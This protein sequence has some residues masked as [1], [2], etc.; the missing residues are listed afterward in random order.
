MTSDPRTAVGTADL[1]RLT[2]TIE[3]TF[4]AARERVFHAWTDCEALARW[5]GPKGW[6]LPFCQIDFRPGGT[7][8]YMMRGEMPDGSMMDAWGKAV[9][10]E[11]DP[12]QR[13]V[14]QD[15]FTDADGNV[16]PGM[17]EMTIEVEFIA[18]GNR[19]RLRSVARFQKAEDIETVLKMGM[20]QGLKD[21]W[22]RLDEYVSA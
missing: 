5:W 21:T 1:E 8:R 7:W 3:R 12:P 20:E 9:Y 2:Y 13:I 11:I 17:P 10:S 18:E 14:Y 16:S 15:F 22:D 19:T 4:G 6:T